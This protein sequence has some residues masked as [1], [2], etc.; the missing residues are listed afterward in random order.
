MKKIAY[1]LLTF[2]TPNPIARYAH[3]SRLSRSVSY[4]SEILQRG[5]T[6][7]D[8]GCGTGHF[9]NAFA[10]NRPDAKI[11]GYDPY[12]SGAVEHFQRVQDITTLAGRSVDLLTCFEVLEHLSDA[13]LAFFVVQAQRLVSPAGAVLISVPIIGGPTLLLKETNR[14]LLYRK[15]S[16]Y[17]IGELLSCALLGIPA[18]RAVR[19]GASH[20]GF[21]FRAL[22]NMLAETFIVE[23][24]MLCP[25]P[26]LPWWLNSQVFLVLRHRI[27]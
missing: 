26:H 4:A 23:R 7:V 12:L 19:R 21:D 15:W 14:M 5:C 16:D 24:E 17:S 11:T 8:F 13:H 20:K 3:R 18:E 22:R 2:D 27:A 6:V 10:R 25:F 1:E 9:L